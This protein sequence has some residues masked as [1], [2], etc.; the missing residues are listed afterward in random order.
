MPTISR[1]S[2]GV[3]IQPLER[4]ERREVGVVDAEHVLV[5]GDRVRLVLEDL[6]VERR[7]AVQ[8]HEPHAGVLGEVRAPLDDLD[9]LVDAAL[10][11]E[12]AI[13]R[14]ERDQIVGPRLVDL[15]PRVDRAPEVAALRLVDLGR[16]AP[17]ALAASSPSAATA[18]PSSTVRTASSHAS[19]LPA[20]DSSF[21]QRR[22]VGDVD[23][24]RARERREREIERAAALLVDLGD[25]VERHDLRRRIGDVLELR[26]EDDDEL[27][28]PVLLAVD[29]LEQLGDA[30]AMLVVDDEPLERSDRALPQRAAADDLLVLVERGRQI[31]EV[32]LEHLGELEP[33]LGRLANAPHRS[34]ARA[35][36]RADRS[37]SRHCERAAE[38][39]LELADRL[40]IRAAR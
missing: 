14:G 21:V 5:R 39:P 32:E 26:V 8:Q 28:P 3:A 38:Q 4:V 23:A 25:L 27:L 30:L 18:A 6:L 12:Q 9:E 17:T 20:S 40:A 13:E 34:R 2:S 36:P 16:A 19:S 15:A 1:A 33:Q 10:E 7:D 37:R 31:V 22:V 11:R 35:A 29:R 24:P